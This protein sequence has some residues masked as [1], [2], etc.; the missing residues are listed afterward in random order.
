MKF[1]TDKCKAIRFGDFKSEDN[2]IMNGQQLD[3]V[4]E[5]KGASCEV[6]F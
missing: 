6:T 5:E 1:N 2:Y 3:W 4:T